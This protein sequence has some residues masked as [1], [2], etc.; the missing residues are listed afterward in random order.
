MRAPDNAENG[1]LF[2]YTLMPTNL[3]RPFLPE[4]L[5]N[6]ELAAPFPFTK[7]CPMLKIQA[8]QNYRPDRDLR[9]TMLF[10]IDSDPEQRTPVSDTTN[11]QKMA[12]HLLRLM[13]A[14]DAPNEQYQ[15]LGLHD[16]AVPG[17]YSS[18]EK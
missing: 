12:D 13:E 7:A 14:R 5:A 4:E 6:A 1:P 3:A 9:T 2:D 16:L 18:P 10:D 8:V 15:R 17:P 11:E